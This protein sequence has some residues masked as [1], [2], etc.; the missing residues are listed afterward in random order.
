VCE[1]GGVRGVETVDGS[2]V[3][4]PIVVSACDP[5]STFVSWLR[6][7]PSSADGLVARWRARPRYEGYESKVDAVITSLPVYRQLDPALAVQL[8]FDPL[9]ATAI[10]APGI[11]AMAAAHRSL[12]DGTVA[13]RPMFFANVPSVL[14][15]TL[16]PAAAAT[17]TGGNGRSGHVFSLETLYTPYELAGGWTNTTEPERWLEVYSQRVEPGFLD[18]LVRHRTMCPESY[19][20]EFFL[21]KGYAPSFAGGPLAALRNRDPEL[22]RY[23]TPIRGLYLTGAATFPG[24]GVWGASGRNAARVILR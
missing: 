13:E 11:D 1:R 7:P 20:R 5:H 6:R 19:E 21:P 4:A 10:I 23:E 16:E 3:E 14:D 24:A 12:H 17:A 22:T 18:G 9:H 15:P 2:V 8:G